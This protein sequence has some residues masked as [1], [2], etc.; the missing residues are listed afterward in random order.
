MA[1][2]TMDYVIDFATYA[3]IPAYLIYAAKLHGTYLVPE[4]LRMTTAIII[5][6]VSTLYYGKEGMVSNDLY[7]VGFPVMWNLVAY[8][9][10]FIFDA[11]PMINFGL[12]IFFAILHFVPIKFPDPIIQR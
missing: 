9:L 10:F 12:I 6:L 4:H 3:I 5:L 7:F 11:S 8:Y 2:K 1:G